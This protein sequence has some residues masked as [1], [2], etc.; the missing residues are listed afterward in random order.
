MPNPITQRLEAI[1]AVVLAK[2][3]GDVGAAVE[4]FERAVAE[5]DELRRLVFASL[6][7][8]DDDDPLTKLTES[9][10]IIAARTRS[11]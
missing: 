4:D 11:R 3:H 2:H 7:P 1:K 8:F 5:D 10:G 9:A 6:D